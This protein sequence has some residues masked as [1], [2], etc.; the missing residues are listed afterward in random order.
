[1]SL[2]TSWFPVLF[3]RTPREAAISY[4]SVA[5]SDAD[6]PLVKSALGIL[7]IFCGLRST[8][9]LTPQAL[10]GGRKGLFLDPAGR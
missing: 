1:M 3:P 9:I 8:K 10:C 2:W 5:L 7:E 6:E 4:C